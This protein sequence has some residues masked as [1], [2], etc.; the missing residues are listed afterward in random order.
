MRKCIV[1]LAK[2]GHI[3]QIMDSGWIFKALLAAKP[4][5]EHVRC[6]DDFVWQ[7]C[8]N[9]IP[10]NSFTHLIAYPIPRCNLAVHNEFGQEKWR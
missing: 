2:V 6:I 4:H 5:Q 3:Q 8:M 9:Y 10:L 7:F 1:A